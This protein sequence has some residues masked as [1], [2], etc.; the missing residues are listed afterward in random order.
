VRTTLVTLA[1]LAFGHP[2]L[3]AEVRSLTIDL[4]SEPD[5]RVVQLQVKSDEFFHVRLLSYV[6]RAVYTARVDRELSPFRTS[7]PGGFR[8]A[9]FS[10]PPSAKLSDW[11]GNCKPLVAA[12][13]DFQLVTA[14]SA[15]AARATEI[16]R[17]SWVGCEPLQ[18]DI[19]IRMGIR[20]WSLPTAYQMEPGDV[21]RVTV[22]RTD[23]DTKQALRIWKFEIRV[24]P[25]WTWRY[26][27]E[28]EWI[29][30]EILSDVAE[31][32]T[33]ARDHNPERASKVKVS[34]CARPDR[35]PGYL[36][37]I[38][39]PDGQ[40]IEESIRLDTGTW[41]P[42]SYVRAA[43]RMVAANRLLAHSGAIDSPLR[44][45]LHP[46]FQV[47][48]TENDRLSRHLA[49]DMTGVAAQEQA[50]LLLGVLGLQEAAGD[51]S[52][53]RALASRATAHLAFAAALRGT[54]A[55]SVEGRVAEA[56]LLTLA[57]RQ[58]DAV[59]R[60]NRLPASGAA[61]AWRR[62]L[63]MRNT[64]DWRV[65]APAQA[66]FLE[67]RER[68]RALLR[69]VNSMQAAAFLATFR[70]EADPDWWRLAFDGASLD[71]STGNL[72]AD[73][74]IPTEVAEIRDAWTRLRP[75]QEPLD[76]AA[77]NSSPGHC[78]SA[79]R[80]SAPVRIIDWGAWAG[81][82]QRHLLHAIASADSHYA[83]ALGLKDASEALRRSARA[84]FSGL[85]LFP[86]LDATWRVG[87]DVPRS[88]RD[89]EALVK[90]SPERVPARTW[91][92][93]VAA[94][95]SGGGVP[96][97]ELWMDPPI[98]AGTAY[99]ATRRWPDLYH[100]RVA[101]A[102]TMAAESRAFKDARGLAPYVSRLA[103]LESADRQRAGASDFDPVSVWGPLAEY[104]L[105][106][107]REVAASFKP[108]SEKRRRLYE[109]LTQ[110]DPDSHLTL[111]WELRSAGL[112]EQAAAAYESA[113]EK[114]LDRVA[115]SHHMG[116][117]IDYHF[118]HG[119]RERAAEIAGA[120]AEV[121]SGSGL[122]SQGRL[123][124]RSGQIAEAET[125][126][127]RLADRYGDAP[128]A[129]R[130]LDCFYIRQH[131]RSGAAR[132]YEREA[133]EAV[134]RL[135]PQGLER[136]SLADFDDAPDFVYLGTDADKAR[137]V[138]QGDQIVAVN[139][140]R[141]RSEDQADCVLSWTDSPNVTTILWRNEE[142]LEVV[143]RD[144]HKTK[145]GP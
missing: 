79:A 83:D 123:L 106:A 54:A 81:H 10:P 98:L 91:R 114:A 103:Y 144:L 124:E 131:R 111:G 104:N 41:S 66:S 53:T 145:Y 97:P 74:A 61:G 121:Y 25:A 136:V 68:Y 9:A 38:A 30:S 126:Y 42:D 32:A 16:R 93:V 87:R 109:R 100:R 29:V 50:A 78:V 15:A 94:C 137:G 62:V 76:W 101:T 138:R 132:R 33:F 21:L 99:D 108:G 23:P 92:R 72:F 130:L 48:E 12:L 122:A 52:D 133:V 45:L 1:L 49:R 40:Q 14:E 22:E 110:L 56:A 24:P 140:Y 6:P 46:S 86:V 142:Y 36:A 141:V 58:V 18:R 55:P 64:G 143:E 90:G 35:V 26:A 75:K 57:W 128:H 89:A 135:F 37:T 112:D 73:A 134:P 8:E 7:T 4:A 118:D 95:A 115:V 27:T 125:W 19:Y 11:A 77:L 70:P 82:F 51:S 69:N 2:A 13:N 119:R 34:L 20:D 96:R 17:G 39:L 129:L 63:N 85:E 105:T 5:D 127:R 113:Y 102:E 65:E 67:R 3:P 47:L 84:S 120:M 71:V 60:A 44:R 139:G 107:M 59:E 80:P 88:C 116:W 28:S 31:M 43:A 117:L